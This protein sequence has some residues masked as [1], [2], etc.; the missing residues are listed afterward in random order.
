MKYLELL[1]DGMSGDDVRLREGID[2][3]FF[4]I[5]RK[6]DMFFLW[7]ILSKYYEIMK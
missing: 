7:V 4:L 5:V 1:C 3:L 6:V 2:F